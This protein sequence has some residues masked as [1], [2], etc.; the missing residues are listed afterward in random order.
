MSRTAGPAPGY[1]D[2]PEHFVEFEPVAKRIRVAFGGETVVD[3]TDALILYERGHVPVYYLPR[4]DRKNELR[5]HG[6]FE[7]ILTNIN[8]KKAYPGIDHFNIDEN[9]ILR[10]QMTK[11]IFELIEQVEA[12]G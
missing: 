1:R 10:G 2:K 8:V 5:P 6:D 12:G 9:E 3:T 4:K 11:R 7:G